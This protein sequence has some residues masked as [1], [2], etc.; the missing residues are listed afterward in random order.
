MHVVCFDPF[1][2]LR[3]RFC[4]SWT[5]RL[6]EF[7]MR[8]SEFGIRNS[9]FR[10]GQ[11]VPVQGIVF[12]H[13]CNEVFQMIELQS[14]IIFAHLVDGSQMDVSVRVVV[15]VGATLNTI[16]DKSVYHCFLR[17]VLQITIESK[18][19]NIP[20]GNPKGAI[21]VHFSPPPQGGSGHLTTPV[22]HGPL[23]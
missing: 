10:I 8:N 9:K 5:I 3:G 6:K 18:S 22:G 17:R 11:P 14:G 16:C 19:K 2:L 23:T 13:V 21:T 7:G 12:R 1:F 20:S 4:S 15:V